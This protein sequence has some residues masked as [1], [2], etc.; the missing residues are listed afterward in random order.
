VERLIKRHKDIARWRNEAELADVRDI[1][2]GFADQTGLTNP[3]NV[4]R[5]YLWTDAH[6]VCTFLGLYHATGDEH[7]RDLAIALVDQVHNVLGRHRDDDSRHGW[8]S[9]LQDEQGRLHPTAGGLRIGKRLPERRSSDAFDERLEWE[10]DG[11]YFHYLTKWMHA[12]CRAADVTRE[13][14]YSVWAQELATAACKG[15]IVAAPGG[16]RMYWKMSIDLSYPLVPS[17]GQ[18]DPLDGYITLHEI[19]LA[20]KSGLGNEI[21]SLADMLGGQTWTTMDPLGIGG[22]LFDAGRV[23]QLAAARQ[24]DGRVL[25]GALVAAT[26]LSLAAYARQPMLHLMA[27]DRLAFRELGLCIGL[28]AID[29]MARVVESHPQH[30][31]ADLGRDLQGLQQYVPLADRIEAFWR[32]TANQQARSWQEHADINAVMLA[33][34][35]LPDEFLAI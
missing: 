21:D 34:S 32:R 11:Q 14:C 18:H 3:G 28:R 7:Y 4:P 33:T 24:L 5:R 31:D 1:M 9:G 23:V 8:I 15:F 30:F 19:A 20:A 10:R 12:L 22:L 6:A 2:L 16:K 17:S 13:A 35:L 26:G 29:G 27:D 25:A